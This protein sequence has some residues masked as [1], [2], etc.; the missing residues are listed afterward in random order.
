MKRLLVLL[1]GQSNMSGRD[2]AEKE[3]LVEI[4]GLIMMAKDLRWRPAIE[5]ITRDRSF[6]G[7]FDSDGNK[8][9]T[10]D[11][12]D[13]VLPDD[14]SR[15]ARGVG[16]GRTFGKLLL[17]ANP[18]CEVGL[19]PMSVGGTGLV[20]W[21]PGGV[22]KWDPIVHPYD[23]AIR[24]AREAQKSGEIVAILWHQGEND[25]AGMNLNYKGQLRTVIENFRR[26]LDLSE[27]IPFIMGELGSFY[28]TIPEKGVA[29]VDEA[30]Y[31]L[32]SEMKGVYVVSAKDLGHRGDNLHFNRKAAVTL[33]QRYFEAFMAC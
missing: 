9:V 7:I 33:G 1:A 4:P 27:S 22:D 19:I 32:A 20:S 26:D 17:E 10:A 24:T 14:D 6:V 31:Q 8:M 11:P 29:M 23:E 5:P 3:D 16:P 2:Y 28:N 12:W 18:G 30:M 15:R 25:A 21:M 13:N